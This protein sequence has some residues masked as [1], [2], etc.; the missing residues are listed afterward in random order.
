MVAA[1]QKKISESATARWIVL[2]LVAFTMLCGYFITDVMAPLKP[3]LEQQMGWSSS[4]YGFFTSA[5][6][7]FNVFLLMLIFGGMILDKM[8][9]R[10]TGLMS[11]VIMVIGVGI[12]YWAIASDF[13]GASVTI[14][15]SVIS[16]Q[17]LWAA[18]GYAIF[19]VGIKCYI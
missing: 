18:I 6:G 9:V 3:M 4:D 5:Y 19:G 17:V 12:K 15:G 1:L 10:F 2:A 7:W 14:F 8:G 16:S 13:G 11:T